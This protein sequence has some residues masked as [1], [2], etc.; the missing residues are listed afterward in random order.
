MGEQKQIMPPLSNSKQEEYAWSLTRVAEGVT[1]N[2]ASAVVL[3]ILAAIIAFL[4][5]GFLQ[6]I[7]AFF[8]FLIIPTNILTTVITISLTLIIAA[9]VVA[10]T[11]YFAFRKKPFT[12]LLTL[13][14]FGIGMKLDA[15]N[16]ASFK[17]FTLKIPHD[18]P[19][20]TSTGKHQVKSTGS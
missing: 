7:Q 15:K 16:F 1:T 2:V 12:V 17:D 13:L 8:R 4:S 5:S 9:L 19:E 6:L 18:K 10:T 11:L 14:G 20:D 3:A